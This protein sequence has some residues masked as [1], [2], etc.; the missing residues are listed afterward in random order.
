MIFKW[1]LWVSLILVVSHIPINYVTPSTIGWLQVTENKR[2][3]ERRGFLISF[4]RWD[5]FFTAYFLRLLFFDQFLPHSYPCL[6][7]SRISS[8]VK[9]QAP[10]LWLTSM[11][12]TH[13]ITVDVMIVCLLMITRI[14]W[15]KNRGFHD[16][17]LD[18]Q[19][20]CQ[21]SVWS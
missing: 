10:R 8:M 17:S 19:G 20:W 1:L 15:A 12:N 21:R 4:I 2:I 7:C 13:C 16:V 9:A 6:L 18:L 11:L 14:S 3:K 5:L